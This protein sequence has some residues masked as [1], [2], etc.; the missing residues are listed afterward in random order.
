[1][2]LSLEFP[3]PKKSE[4]LSLAR[5]AGLDAAIARLQA[6]MLEPD[7]PIRAIRH[8]PATEGQF[9][10]IPAGVPADLAKVLAGR[11]IA[12]L[13]THQAECYQ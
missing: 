13:Y 8:Q 11:G 6:S 3:D 5:R 7:S 1:M 9:E 4:S 10:D 12:R 2:N